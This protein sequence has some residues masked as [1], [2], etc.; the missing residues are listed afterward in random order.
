MK[1]LKANVL[2]SCIGKPADL[3]DETHPDWAPT[4]N[5]RHSSSSV[6]K[7][8]FQSA[9]AR[10]KRAKERQNKK[11]KCVQELF[12][13]LDC[14]SEMNIIGKGD[15]EKENIDVKTSAREETRS[16]ECTSIAIQTELSMQ[17][18]EKVENL[19]QS[20]EAGNSVLSMSWFE[21]DE[22]RVK[23]YTGLTA[24]SVLMAVF[25]LI[26]PPLPERKSISKFQQL[27]ITFMRLT[28]YLSVQDLA[29]RFGVHASTVSR[30]F[31]TYMQVMCTFMAFLVK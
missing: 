22:E 2:F 3:Y 4:K 5:M 7:P 24:M 23:F 14:E 27:L 30:V 15:S 20:Q 25:D 12:K 1:Q 31:Q 9:L 6:S 19:K 16:L 26:I 28:L 29:Y 8:S 13:E 18:I 17:N 21:A 11:R 10:Q